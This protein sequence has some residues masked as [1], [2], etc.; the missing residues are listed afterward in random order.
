MKRYIPLSSP[1]LLLV[2]GGQT[3]PL[4]YAR[5]CW[6]PVRLP[7]STTD[8]SSEVKDSVPVISQSSTDNVSAQVK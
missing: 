4:A 2:A 5:N 6:K 8:Y 3:T 7:F 1:I